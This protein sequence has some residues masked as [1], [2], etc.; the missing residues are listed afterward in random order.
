MA[1]LF[2]PLITKKLDKIIYL[3]FLGKGTGIR[4]K[5]EELLFA[6]LIYPS[7]QLKHNTW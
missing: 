4:K 2:F 3:Y 5:Q 7:G 6:F 1:C